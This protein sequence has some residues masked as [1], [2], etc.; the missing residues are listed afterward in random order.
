MLSVVIVIFLLWTLV[1]LSIEKF[2]LYSYRPIVKWALKTGGNT[3]YMFIITNILDR[4][5][6]NDL[7]AYNAQMEYISS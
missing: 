2:N 3:Q 7:H 1:L 4:T 6:H 5:T